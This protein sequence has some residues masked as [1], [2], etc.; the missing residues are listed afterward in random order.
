MEAYTLGNGG[1]SDSGSPIF[2]APM[3]DNRSVVAIDAGGYN[4]C[5][6]LDNGSVACWGRSEL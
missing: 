4:V 3:P 6:L 1:A 2:T 5:A